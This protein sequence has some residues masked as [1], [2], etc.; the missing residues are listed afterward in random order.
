[1]SQTKQQIEALLAGAGLAPERRLGQHFLI[2]GNLMR[3]LVEE[4]GLTDGQ[5][6]LEVGAG[7]GSLTGL[8][9]EAVGPGGRVVAVEIDHRLAAIAG[10]QLRGY[11]NVRLLCWDVLAR[12][13]ALEPA[14]VE[15]L[16]E[17]SQQG[18]GEIVLVANLPYQASA[19][20][21]MNLLGGSPTCTAMTVTVQAELAERMTAAAGTKAYG[22]L[23]ILLQATG[24][25]R[26]LRTVGPTAFWPMPN[27]YS[28]IISW[29]RDEGKCRQIA[30]W[31]SLKRVVEMLLQHRRKTIQSCL[32]LAAA[33]PEAGALLQRAGIDGAARGETLAPEQFVAL[34]NLW[35]GRPAT[36]RP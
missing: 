14:V 31:S 25:V 34:A 7:T 8:L 27:V 18:A 29:R 15:A 4:A 12:K 32:H 11:A 9:A 23:G 6:V 22:T 13:S 1:V 35:A 36:S 20:L 16:R 28:A 33:G 19:P 5:T 10:E 26:R 21:M 2:D 17:A 30:E 24:E 3:L